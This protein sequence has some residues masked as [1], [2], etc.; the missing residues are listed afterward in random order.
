MWI[1]WTVSKNVEHLIFSRLKSV[2]PWIKV[3]VDINTWCMR[4]DA[5]DVLS[6]MMMT[7][8]VSEESL[9]RKHTQIHRTHTQTHRDRVWIRLS[10]ATLKTKKGYKLSVWSFWF[11][12]TNRKCNEWNFNW[13]K[14]RN[15]IKPKWSYGKNRVVETIN[16]AERTH[17]GLVKV[18]FCHLKCI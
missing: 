14:F 3:K 17:T 13:H 6:L 15:C 5:V 1:A 7:E 12:D 8:K 16:G 11:F 18:S 2:W 4:S 10:L 9:A